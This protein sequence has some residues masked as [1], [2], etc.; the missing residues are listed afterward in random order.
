MAF[1]QLPESPGIS[2]SAS[3]MPDQEHV[4]QEHS[5]VSPETHGATADWKHVLTVCRHVRQLA[6][7]GQQGP[8]AVAPRS[9]RA[10]VCISAASIA[11]ATEARAPDCAAVTSTPCPEP[12][13]PICAQCVDACSSCCVSLAQRRADAGR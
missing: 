1:E 8:S 9:A 4:R 5:S 12:L 13:P 2:H 10:G 7:N 11:A 6:R 3:A